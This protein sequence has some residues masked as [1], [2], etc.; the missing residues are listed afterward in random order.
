MSVNSSD[1]IQHLENE[2]R[3]RAVRLAWSWGVGVPVTTLVVWFIL[4]LIA[5]DAA[6]TSIAPI[7]IAFAGAVGVCVNTSRRWSRL[8][9]W[10][11]LMG[12]VWALIPWFVLIAT[13]FLPRFILD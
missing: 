3:R 8:H 11:P 9:A 4:H 2:D 12:A 7:V 5:P 13:T 1:P 10:A 6:V